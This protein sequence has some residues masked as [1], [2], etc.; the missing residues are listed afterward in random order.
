MN[1]NKLAL[2]WSIYECIM[3]IYHLN[4]STDL[5]IESHTITSDMGYDIIYASGIIHG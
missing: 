5:T 4:P 2:L 1:I 3:M